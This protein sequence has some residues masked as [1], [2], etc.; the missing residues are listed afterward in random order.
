MELQGYS[1]EERAS[2]SDRLRNFGPVTSLA[3]VAKYLSEE[4]DPFLVIGV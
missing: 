3:T 4:E 1:T 2:L